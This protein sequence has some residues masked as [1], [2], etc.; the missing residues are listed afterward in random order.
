VRFMLRMRMPTDQGNEVIKD[1]SLGPTVQ[2]ILEEMNAEASY[3]TTVDGGFPDT[4][5][6]RTLLPHVR[7][8]HRFRPRDEP[9]RP[10]KSNPSDRAGRS[11]VR[12]E[13]GRTTYRLGRGILRGIPAF[14]INAGFAWKNRS[15]KYMVTSSAGPVGSWTGDESPQTASSRPSEGNTRAGETVDLEPGPKRVGRQNRRS[16]PT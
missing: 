14:S 6:D 16:R 7:G 3:F 2:S 12:L 4:R 8:H 15:R 1:G 9:G 5:R 10:G 13:E 11:E